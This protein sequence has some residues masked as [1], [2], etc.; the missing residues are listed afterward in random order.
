[1]KNIL[2]FGAGSIGNHM[3]YACS[4]KNYKVHITDISNNALVRMKSKIFPLR[5]GKWNKKI[6]LINYRDVFK[7]KIFFD[8]IIV[9]TPPITHRN[10][11]EKSKNNLKFKKILIEKPITNYLD[12]R[13]FNL[14]KYLKTI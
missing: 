14:V 8:L 13:I 6:N 7:L 10:L 4:K 5:Y 12:N 3:A 1:M 2:I 11:F 9:G